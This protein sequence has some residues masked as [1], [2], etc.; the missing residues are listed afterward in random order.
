MSKQQ[1]IHPVTHAKAQVLKAKLNAKRIANGE[2]LLSL[3]DV[4][5]LA[6]TKLGASDE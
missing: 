5:D 4:Y 1:R 2:K 3:P 6:I